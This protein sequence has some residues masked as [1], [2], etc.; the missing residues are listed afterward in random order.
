MLDLTITNEE[1]IRVTAQPTTS[2]GRPATLDGPIR[3][4]V[5]SGDGTVAAGASDLEV[6]LR[7]GDNPGDTTYLIEAD[8]DLGAGIVLVQDTAMLHVTGAMASS[9]GLTAGSPES[10]S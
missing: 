4:T 10:K 7:S 2:T 1:Q 3:A 9:L 8:A 6:V 5:L